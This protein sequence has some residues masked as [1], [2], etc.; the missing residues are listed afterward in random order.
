MNIQGKEYTVFDLAHIYAME[1]YK[2]TQN[3]PIY[4]QPNHARNNQLPTGIIGYSVIVIYPLDTVKPTIKK[5]LEKNGFLRELEGTQSQL[6]KYVD[7]KE[8]KHYRKIMAYA[9]AY[10]DFIST[11]FNIPCKA[12]HLLRGNL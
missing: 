9:D 4:I 5:S 1:A 12:Q 10:A 8:N 6:K 2:T 3:S 11:Q 7:M